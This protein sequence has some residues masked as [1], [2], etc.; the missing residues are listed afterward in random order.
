MAGINETLNGCTLWSYDG[1][2]GFYRKGEH[3]R[4]HGVFLLYP[5]S[6]RK[7]LSAAKMD[8]G[9]IKTVKKSSIL[10]LRARC[11]SKSAR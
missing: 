11:V 9:D 5:P 2:L 6:E 7:G 8:I 1:S 10:I 4:G 3:V